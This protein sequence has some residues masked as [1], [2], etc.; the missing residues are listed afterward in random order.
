MRWLWESNHFCEIL[1]HEYIVGSR[2]FAWCAPVLAVG[3]GGPRVESTRRSG[4]WPYVAIVTAQAPL[5]AVS[6]GLEQ[7]S[8]PTIGSGSP[9]VGSVRCSDVWL[10][11]AVATVQAPLGWCQRWLEAGPLPGNRIRQPRGQIC[12]VPACLAHSCLGPTVHSGSA[13]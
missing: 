11:P 13:A 9:E 8:F 6:G 5:G 1:N 7:A 2:S 4:V 3:S 10:S 12:A